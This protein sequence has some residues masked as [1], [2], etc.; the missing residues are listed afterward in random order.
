M[1]LK[2]KKK[3]TVEAAAKAAA[4]TGLIAKGSAPRLTA[5]DLGG[6]KKVAV[7]LPGETAG[8]ELSEVELMLGDN[9]VLQQFGHLYGAGD[10]VWPASVALARMLAHVPSLTAGKRVLELGCG[11]AVSGLASATAGAASVLLTDRDESVLGLVQQSVEANGIPEGQVTTALL[12]WG[13]DAETLAEVLGPEPID[14]IIGADILYDETAPAKLA[15]LLDSL[16]PAGPRAAL[17]ANAV[18]PEPSRVLLADPEQRL[19]R[20]A[21]VDACADRGLSAVDDALPGPEKMRLVAVVR[22]NV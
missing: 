3:T 5:V 1:A 18:A 11:L 9:G 4:A 6:G 14:V 12:E 19:H 7:M 17:N 10:V 15:N 20:Q 22:D 13:S 21:F 8:E 2:T 16:L